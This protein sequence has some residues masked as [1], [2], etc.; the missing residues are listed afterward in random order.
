MRFSGHGSFGVLIYS[1]WTGSIYS[2][3]FSSARELSSMISVQNWVG[4]IYRSS[5]SMMGKD[6]LGI[7]TGNWRGSVH[8]TKIS[9]SGI[10]SMGILSYKWTGGLYS[11]NIL[12]SGSRSTG[13]FVNG[14]WKGKISKSKI[15]ANTKGSFG[16]YIFSPKSKGTISKSTVST[17]K[18]R[19]ISVPKSIKIKDTK[20]FAKNKSSRIY[21]LG[22]KLSV[23]RFQASYANF[24]LD[25][26]GRGGNRFYTVKIYN[27]GE[28]ISKTSSLT[29]TTGSGYRKV[30]KIKPIKAGYYREITIGVPK[31]IFSNKLVKSARITYSNGENK[32]INSK[33]IKFR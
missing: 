7:F 31:S 33:T 12:A 28:Y 6:N 27:R 32:K 9:A 29:I 21:I 1:K 14:T 20:V 10:R 25:L 4:S 22:P 24:F 2:S 17:K 11:S 15:N 26:L 16:V 30:V 23:G 18:G 13:L 8:N 3:S 19:A 5:I